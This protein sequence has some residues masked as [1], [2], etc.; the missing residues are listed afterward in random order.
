[1]W[2]QGL[3][4]F[5]ANCSDPEHKKP[6]WCELRGGP[7]RAGLEDLQAHTADATALLLGYLPWGY[8]LFCDHWTAI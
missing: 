1:M 3:M 7:E 6:W 5:G 8:T 4:E 2:H